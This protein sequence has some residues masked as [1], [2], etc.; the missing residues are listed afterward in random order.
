M[1]VS[2][3]GPWGF[4]E[5]LIIIEKLKKTNSIDKRTKKIKKIF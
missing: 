1:L 2:N 5:L 4:L 3:D